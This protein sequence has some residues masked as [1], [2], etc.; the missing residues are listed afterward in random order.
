MRKITIYRPKD[1]SKVKLIEDGKTIADIEHDDRIVIRKV[2]G[3]I[4]EPDVT[5][6]TDIEPPVSFEYD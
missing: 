6:H 3:M 1:K 2:D 5:E 4:I